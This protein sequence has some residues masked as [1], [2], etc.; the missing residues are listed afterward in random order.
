MKT[1]VGEWRKTWK[2]PRGG[3]QLA[4]IGMTMA[5][6]MPVVH[7]IWEPVQEGVTGWEKKWSG[8]WETAIDNKRMVYIIHK[9]SIEYGPNHMPV[10]VTEIWNVYERSDC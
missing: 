3:C 9:L 8:V 7:E 1:W 2:G 5:D 4:H 6:N 10:Q